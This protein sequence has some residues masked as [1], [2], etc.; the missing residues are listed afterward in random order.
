M[1]TVPSSRKRL[2]IKIV[3]SIVLPSASP[4]AF[5]YIFRLYI[6]IWGSSRGNQRTRVDA[7]HPKNDG[8]EPDDNRRG[9]ARLSGENEREVSPERALLGKPYERRQRDDDREHFHRLSFTNTTR[10]TR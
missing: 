1:T 2:V 9:Q 6:K 4:L 5:G 3:S 10:R 8:R 7:P